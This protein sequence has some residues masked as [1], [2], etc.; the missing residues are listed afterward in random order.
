ME[1]GKRYPQRCWNQRHKE[2]V[3]LN[4]MLLT[5][6]QDKHFHFYDFLQNC[7]IKFLHIGIVRHQCSASLV[8][9]VNRE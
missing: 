7:V 5:I 1:Q 9:L 2:G 4:E 3:G 8:L 6:L